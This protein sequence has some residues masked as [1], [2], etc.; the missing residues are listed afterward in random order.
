LDELDSDLTYAGK[1]QPLRR[2]PLEDVPSR[3]GRA[4][5]RS[6]DDD[7]ANC[8]A[9][10]GRAR[11]EHRDDAALVLTLTRRVGPSLRNY[12][13]KGTTVQ[14]RSAG[15]GSTI[16][17]KSNPKAALDERLALF[18]ADTACPAISS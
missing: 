14:S 4:P 8:A 10:H 6:S 2:D 9:G 1:A 15:V 5:R 17:G 16:L 7:P 11:A 18:S 12:Q 3:P 13:D